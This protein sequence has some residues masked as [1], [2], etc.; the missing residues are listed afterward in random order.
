MLH[1]CVHTKVPTNI[2]GCNSDIVDTRSINGNVCAMLI[3]SIS[4]A[5]RPEIYDEGPATGVKDSVPEAG[6][7]SG[8]GA[9]S[10]VD[11]SA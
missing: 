11:D 7:L 9:G 5:R 8:G 4:H 3:G 10:Q 6:V 1:A 2:S